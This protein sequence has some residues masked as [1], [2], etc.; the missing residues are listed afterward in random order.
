MSNV[1]DYLFLEHIIRLASAYEVMEDMV[2]MIITDK[3]YWAGYGNLEGNLTTF[4]NCND[5]FYWASADLEP[6][7]SDSDL[8]LFEECLKL[9]DIY[10]ATIYACRKRKMRPQNCILEKMPDNTKKHLELCGP[11]RTNKECG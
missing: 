1:K 10:G 7:K 6:I 8:K 9:D 3:G 11:P 2:F 5:L 4:V